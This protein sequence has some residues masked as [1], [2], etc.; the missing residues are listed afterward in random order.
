MPMTLKTKY[1]ELWICMSASKIQENAESFSKIIMF[2][3]FQVL[4]PEHVGKDVRRKLLEI[5][6]INA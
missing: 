6:R 5:R 1:F 2:G 3:E 4:K